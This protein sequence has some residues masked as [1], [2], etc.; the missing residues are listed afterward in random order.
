[1]TMANILGLLGICMDITGAFILVFG[2]FGKKYNDLYHE[3]AS[4]WGYNQEAFTS[5][6]GQKGLGIAGFTVLLFGFVEQAIACLPYKFPYPL[7]VDTIVITIVN[8][9]CVFLVIVFRRY[10]ISFY[11]GFF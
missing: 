10:I 3:S 6:A 11:V 7:L 1:M 8:I 5:L 2:F 4:A 9:A